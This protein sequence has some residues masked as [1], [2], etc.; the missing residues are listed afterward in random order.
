ML[1]WC[2]LGRECWGSPSCFADA[3]FRHIRLGLWGLRCCLV[4]SCTFRN[5]FQSVL[6]TI[7]QS[8]QDH[9]QDVKGRDVKDLHDVDSF[10]LNAARNHSAVCLIAVNTMIAKSKMYSGISPSSGIIRM[11]LRISSPRAAR[12]AARACGVDCRR[13]R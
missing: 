9:Q 10:S 12:K 3:L 6:Y 4:A 1:V 5:S 11:R 2:I 13:P 7:P 8:L